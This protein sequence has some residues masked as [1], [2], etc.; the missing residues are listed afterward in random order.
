MSTPLPMIRHRGGGVVIGIGNPLRGD[1]AVGL[2]VA[3]ELA[4]RAGCPVLITE[5][6]P[7][8]YLD[9]VRRESP[10]WV[11]LVDAANLGESPGASAI[12]RMGRG[13][14][15]APGA[16]PSTHRPSLSVLTTYIESEI[17]A[18]VWLL[19]IQPGSLEP[20]AALSAEVA[21]GVGKAADLAH[22]W[23]QR[24]PAAMEG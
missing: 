19:G 7:E 24:L 11:L 23:I 22:S 10:A 3:R 16:L 5:E 15:F 13:A 20:G 4:P 18:D 9:R 2:A 8:N 21:S 14:T 6:T 17:G 1:D 12:V